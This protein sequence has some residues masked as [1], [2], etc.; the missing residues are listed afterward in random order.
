[1]S[2]AHN[3]RDSL[4]PITTL[5]ALFA[6][7]LPSFSVGPRVNGVAC[8]VLF[9]VTA[10][11]SS[12]DN[13]ITGGLIQL[14]SRSVI[15]SPSL[16]SLTPF[17]GHSYTRSSFTRAPAPTALDTRV[18][19][20]CLD[21]VTLTYNRKEL[22]VAAGAGNVEIALG[23]VGSR[24]KGSA[25]EAGYAPLPVGGQERNKGRSLQAKWQ[26]PDEYRRG[27]KFT[28]NGGFGE[29]C[30]SNP[31]PGLRSPVRWSLRLMSEARG[32]NMT[33]SG[34]E[35]GAHAGTLLFWT[36]KVSEACQYTTTSPQP[37][38]S[39]HHHVTS[40]VNVS[41]NQKSG[42]QTRTKDGTNRRPAYSTLR[43]FQGLT[44][45][46]SNAFNKNNFVYIK[47]V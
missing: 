47:L 11:F 18:C 14:S 7:Y 43:P 46:S 35:Q 28:R 30:R 10:K 8:V 41:S 20:T 31:F 4:P 34:Q 26:H 24:D 1:R 13:A 39:S 27:S 6:V 19:G 37:K 38:K 42:T 22:W 33:T 16:T 23:F 36:G 3:L 17:G 32:S 44:T 2:I 45:F 9:S 15:A 12:R 29:K 25:I 21:R 5:E 40:A